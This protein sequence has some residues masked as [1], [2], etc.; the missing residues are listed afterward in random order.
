MLG[1]RRDMVT[2]HGLLNAFGFVACGA[3]AHLR[4]GE[5]DHSV[6]TITA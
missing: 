2:T 5:P 3:I 4:L 1:R 6:R